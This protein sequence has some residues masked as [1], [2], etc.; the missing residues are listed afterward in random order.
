ME[1]TLS[2]GGTGASAPAT[3]ADSFAPAAS[4]AADPSASSPPSPATE[5]PAGTEP[6]STPGPDRSPY[7]DR[8]R[9]DQINERMKAAETFRQ[10]H[11]WAETVDRAAIAEAQRIGQQYQQDKHGFIRELLTDAM[12]DASLAP[13]VRSEAA[14]LLG[15]RAQPAG[16]PPVDL[17]PIQIQLENGQVVPL[18]N[19][20]QLQALKKEWM[21][22]ARTEFAP[23]M[24]TAKQLEAA[25]AHYQRQMQADGFAKAFYGDL[26]KLPGFAEHRDVIR[27]HLAT[28][29]LD[30]DHPAEVRAAVFAIYNREVVP[31]LLAGRDSQ[32]LDALQQKAAAATSVNPGRAGAASPRAVTKFSDLGP[33]AWR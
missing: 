27:Q 14:R 26:S 9:F 16:P 18:Y 17:T 30:T 8:A 32:V 33:E 7:V 23:A 29:K 28:A 11:A 13:L 6:T 2:D 15:T 12:N 1:A 3:F 21:E 31:K 5:V 19:A 22:E 20:D 4:P 24:Q 25:T 10:Q